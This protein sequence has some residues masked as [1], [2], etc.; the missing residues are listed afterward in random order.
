[1]VHMAFS[2]ALF[3]L[4][5]IKVE[6]NDCSNEAKNGGSN[7]QHEHSTITQWW[8]EPKYHNLIITLLNLK[9]SDLTA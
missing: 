4:K 2:F 7:T 9:A 6:L 5:K 3:V 1:M 8:Q